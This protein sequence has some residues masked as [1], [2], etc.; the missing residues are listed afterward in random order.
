MFSRL[1][2]KAK[3]APR[4]PAPQP[5]ATITVPTAAIPGRVVARAAAAARAPAAEAAREQGRLVRQVAALIPRVSSP[6]GRLIERAKAR[7]VPVRRPTVFAQVRD[8]ARARVA[9]RPP[10]STAAV[11]VAPFER[12]ALLPA[13]ATAL[14]MP[15]T[16]PFSLAPIMEPATPS[17]PTMPAYSDVFPEEGLYETEAEPLEE[18]APVETSDVPAW[19]ADSAY[20]S[21]AAV[22]PEGAGTREPAG[23]QLDPLDELEQYEEL[24]QGGDI[25]QRELDTLKVEL[26]QRT[27][28]TQ[29]VPWVAI[30]GLGAL[31]LWSYSSQSGR[32]G[33]GGWR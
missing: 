4:P 15:A 14:T 13:P 28:A 12:A 25:S 17:S 23:A 6:V 27:G 2:E 32:G 16:S 18:L 7:P 3:A 11:P 30:A 1:I 19:W 33:R 31:L 26:A 20:Q 9:P 8:R 29:R 5:R 10:G 21:P 24:A 22:D